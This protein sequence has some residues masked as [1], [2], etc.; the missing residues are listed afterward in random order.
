MRFCRKCHSL[1]E[2][3]VSFCPDCGTKLVDAHRRGE[4]IK[5]QPQ[6]NFKPSQKNSS[7]VPVKVD[8]GPKEKFQYKPNLPVIDLSK[9]KQLMGNKKILGIAGLTILAVAIYF[10]YGAYGSSLKISFSAFMSKL[11]ANSLFPAVNKTVSA[12][13]VN[14]TNKTVEKKCVDVIVEEEVKVPYQ[15]LYKYSIYNSGLLPTNAALIGVENLENTAATF[16]I[17]AEFKV[18]GSSALINSSVSEIILGGEK[19]SFEI[20]YSGSEEVLLNKP[21]VEPPTEN[22]YNT[23]MQNKTVQQCS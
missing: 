7:K 5:S 8:I 6:Q 17:I 16:K 19:K 22:R 23:V 1:Q 13:A 21:Y 2:D 4:E 14:E 15:Y 10:A 11:N 20:P 18:K 3:S 9:A 12:A